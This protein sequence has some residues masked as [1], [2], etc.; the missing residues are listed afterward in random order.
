ADA[1]PQ[2][3]VRPLHRAYRHV[4]AVEAVELAG[5]AELIDREALEQQL[6]GLVIHRLGRGEIERVILAFER[7]HAAADAELEAAAAQLVEH[8]DFLYQAQRMIERQQEDHRP[9]AQPSG[10]PWCSAR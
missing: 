1:V 4:H 6:K 2:R 8:A 5:E 7:R 3:R 9:E 10:V